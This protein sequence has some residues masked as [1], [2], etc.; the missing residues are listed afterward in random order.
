MPKAQS[1][2]NTRQRSLRTLGQGALG[3]ALAA[4]VAEYVIAGDWKIAGGVA[5]TAVLGYLTSVAQNW[6]E[7][8]KR[9]GPVEE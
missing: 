3:A 8:L 6:A 5:L 1:K 7:N 9:T 2:R 4:P